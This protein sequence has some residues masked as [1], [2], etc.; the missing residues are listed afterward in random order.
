MNTHIRSILIGIGLT[1][2][3][4][5][6]SRVAVSV[7]GRVLVWDVLLDA[8]PER[9]WAAAF[10]S[11]NAAEWTGGTVEIAEKRGGTLHLAIGPHRFLGE[12]VEIEAHRVV[13]ARL[14]SVSSPE[15]RARDLAGTQWRAR[16]SPNRDGGTVLRLSAVRDAG[17]LGF[18]LPTWIGHP[19]LLALARLREHLA[20]QREMGRR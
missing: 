2:L 4:G 3:I 8:A 13:T 15:P 1:V 12:I 7:P 10:T 14:V 17:R 20:T 5:A 19:V 9:V 18:E 6:E 16:L 11:K